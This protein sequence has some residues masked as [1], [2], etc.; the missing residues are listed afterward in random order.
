M[1]FATAHLDCGERRRFFT[2]EDKDTTSDSPLFAESS[3]GDDLVWGAVG[4]ARELGINRRAPFIF[5]KGS[6][7]LPG[8]WRHM[9]DFP[10]GV[11]RH[12]EAES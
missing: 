5:W 12:L 8:S 7:C 3:L 4:L 10:K 2:R 1:P 11:R 6:G 9:G